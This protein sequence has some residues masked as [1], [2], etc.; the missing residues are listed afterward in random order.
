MIMDSV[1]S[2]WC[3]QKSCPVIH[4]AWSTLLIRKWGMIASVVCKFF[5]FGLYT[6][7]LVFKLCG[8]TDKDFLYFF[9]DLL[10]HTE[11]HRQGLWP[12]HWRARRRRIWGWI[13]GLLV[14]SFFHV[15]LLAFSR[16]C[17]IFNTDNVIT[18]TVGGRICCE[19]RLHTPGIHWRV[20]NHFR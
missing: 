1:L 6:N 17:A 12:C 14:P 18:S 4:L 2:Y 13:S 3:P 10:Q 20:Q 19:S 15:F 11:V 9:S 8:Y 16:L 7:W 5:T